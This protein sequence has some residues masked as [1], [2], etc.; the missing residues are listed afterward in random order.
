M[1][2]LQKI[3]LRQS[4]VRSKIAAELDRSEEERTEGEL[5][6]L[7]R[8]AQSVEVE[9][10]AALTIEQE[11]AIPDTVETPEGRELAELFRRSSL[12]EFVNETLTGAP[13]DGANLEL[14]SHLLGE[15]MVGY[16]PLDYAAGTR[17]NGSA[18]AGGWT[19]RDPRRCR[20]ERGD[21]PFRTTSRHDCGQSVCTVGYSL[22]G[23]A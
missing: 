6:R 9:L 23:R 14:R 17:T 15:N 11:Q 10:R 19:V 7:T 12:A 8:E 3:R 1:T 4:E 21:R 2:R 5:E 22:S 16:L 20:H 13:L 18:G